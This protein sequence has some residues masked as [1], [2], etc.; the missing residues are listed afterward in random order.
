MRMSWSFLA[1]VVPTLACS[2][3]PSSLATADDNACE[4][5][6]GTADAGDCRVA[7]GA[8]ER[9][10]ESG[11][12]EA[13]CTLEYQ[14]SAAAFSEKT[15]DCGSLARTAESAARDV[16]HHCLLDA[17]MVG[18]PVQLI[19][20]AQ[21]IDSEIAYAYVAQGGKNPI[22]ELMFDSN[23]S[24]FSST[25][26]GAIS[27]R[28]CSSIRALPDCQPSAQ[29]MCIE[30]VGASDSSKVCEVPSRSS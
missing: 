3:S 17:L 11:Q 2:D 28:I 8:S 15:V 25:G 16:A 12:C 27:E 19:E 29:R 10:N 24:G 4:A 1:L 30:C 5:V 23:F 22:Q 18:Q 26:G 20:W 21:G 14:V 6:P 7:C 9:R 13:V